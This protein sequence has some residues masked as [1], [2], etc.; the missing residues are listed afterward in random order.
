MPVFQT[1]VRQPGF[2]P[3]TG[4]VPGCA[5]ASVLELVSGGMCHG[6]VTLLTSVAVLVIGWIVY[7][8]EKV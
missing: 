1:F 6:Q 2:E 4:T 8:F 3:V 5:A 7:V